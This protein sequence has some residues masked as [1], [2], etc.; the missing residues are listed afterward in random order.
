MFRVMI[1]DPKIKS[2]NTLK[3]MLKNSM[4]IEVL[5]VYSNTK[6]FLKEFVNKTT[7]IVFIWITTNHYNGMHLA[8][9]I[10]KSCPNTKVI[11]F[12]DRN[13]LITNAFE[14][15]VVDYLFFKFS[16]NIVNETITNSLKTIYEECFQ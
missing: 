15:K 11:F 2:S 8:R 6:N 5:G 7:D 10:C 1:I 13:K 14:P 12:S 3:N 16:E 9:A 4:D